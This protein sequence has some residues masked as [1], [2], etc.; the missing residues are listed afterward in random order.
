[1]NEFN[2]ENTPLAFPCRIGVKAMGH[3]GAD[4]PERVE[5]IAGH[6]A[7]VLDTRSTGS[8]NG[9]YVSVTVT[10]EAHSRDQLEGLYQALH[11]DSAVMVTL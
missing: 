10:V 6:H 1:M 5:R 8:R 3:A 2:A 7:R 11:E 9:R 4:L